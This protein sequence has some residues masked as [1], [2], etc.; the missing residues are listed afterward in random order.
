MA[1]GFS[2]SS[3]GQWLHFLMTSQYLSSTA[4]SLVLAKR[5]TPNNSGSVSEFTEIGQRI[6]I[7]WMCGYAYKHSHAI[8]F[9]N[10][11]KQT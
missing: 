1:V 8:L 7:R 5:W 9:I 6:K 10:I 4:F 3:K 11:E 2:N